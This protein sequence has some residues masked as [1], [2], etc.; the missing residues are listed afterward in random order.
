MESKV[1]ESLPQLMDAAD[2]TV[3]NDAV[4]TAFQKLVAQ[5]GLDER[6]GQTMMSLFDQGGTE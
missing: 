3:R 4:R 6:I 5:A 1:N 2:N